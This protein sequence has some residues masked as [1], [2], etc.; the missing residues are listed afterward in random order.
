MPLVC[1]AG[2]IRLIEE[3]LNA[4]YKGLEAA[5]EGQVRCILCAVDLY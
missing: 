3:Q 2:S 4:R 5:R 1:Y